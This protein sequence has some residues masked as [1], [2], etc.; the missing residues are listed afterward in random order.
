MADNFIRLGNLDYDEIKSSLKDFMQS[1]SDLGFDF[2]GSI[3]ATVLDLLTYN[4]LYYA[5]YSN[6]L[7]NESFLE[8]AQR[9][10]SVI[11]LVKPFGYAISHRASASANLN[12]ENNSGSPVTLSPYVSAFTA[13]ASSGINYTFYYTGGADEEVTDPQSGEVYNQV[14]ISDGS[15]KLISVYQG[16][17]A[18]INLPVSVDYDNQKF[19]IRD[20]SVDIRTLRVYVQESDGLKQYTRIDNTNSSISKQDRVYYLETSN[21]GYTVYFGAPRSDDG[22][23]TGRGVGE[24]ETVYVSYLSSTGSAAN[25]SK[26]WLSGSSI[27][28]TNPNVIAKG[29]FDSPNI[30]TVKFMGPRE[31]ASAGR[32]V[33]VSDYQKAIVDVGGFNIS[34]VDTKRNVGV[35]GSPQSAVRTTGTVFFSL[36][37]QINGP[38]TN[39]SNSTITDIKNDLDDQVM[40]GLTFDY[41]V[42]TEAIITFNLNGN[43]TI[44]GEN[45]STGFNQTVKESEVGTWSTVQ[46]GVSGPIDQRRFDLKNKLETTYNSNGTPG[47]ED[48]NTFEVRIMDTAATPVAQIGVISGSGVTNIVANSQT[49]GTAD[50][51]SG[52]V[53]LD[54]SKMSE[55][56]GISANYLNTLNQIKIKDEL[57]GYLIA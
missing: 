27:T 52:L 1:Q 43:S 32:L 50:T 46:A 3:A 23:I 44:F 24:M 49:I 45:H 5:F 13:T 20:T 9:I 57:L 36:Y 18:I 10:E 11:S 53:V 29:G 41:K 48:G 6:M 42:P 38:F 7:I 14:T 37:D 54:D 55:L 2:D 39:A 26:S 4:T 31:F 35:Y 34:T 33:T 19:E 12:I 21:T 25:G 40:V 16:K 47:G 8:S 15:S 17:S 51:D 56:Q 28:I 30:N 22:N